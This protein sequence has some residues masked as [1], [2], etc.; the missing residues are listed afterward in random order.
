MRK[1][2]ICLLGILSFVFVQAQSTFKNPII[3][4]MNPDPSICRVGDDFYL[5]TST[6]E[7][8]P[9]LPVYQSK[10]LVHW[11][12]I[13]YALTTPTQ[14]PLMGCTS[15]TGGQYAP[16]IR[17]NNGTFYVICTNYGGQGSQ[18]VFYV[19]ASNPAGPWSNPRW[20]GNWY[21]DPSLMFEN[22]STYFLSPD[23]NGS[24]LL[25]TIN[26]VTGKFIKPL[27]KIA[28]GLGGAA[29]EG[30]HMY[31]INDYYYLM[32]A[33]GGTGY[34]HREVIQRSSSPWGPFVPSPVNPVVSH[35]T[36]PKNPFQAIGHADLVQLP[37]NSWWLVCLGFRPRNGNYHHLGRETFLAPV[38]WSA[39]GWP[40]G[41]TAGIVAE[42]MAVPNLPEY[43]WPEEPVRDDFDSIALRSAWNFI[44]NPHAADWSLSA[45]P[46]FLRLKG[47]KISFREKDS[48]AFIGRRQTA[49]N[50]VASASANFI[51]V[52]GNEEA[53]LVVRG[54]DANHF[55]FVITKLGGKRVLM[56]RK[57]LQDKTTDFKYKE[58]SDSGNVILRISSTDLQYKF[59]VQ[60][61]GKTAE[62]IGTTSTIDLS[63]EKIGG[64]TGT[65]IGMYASGNGFVNVNPADFDWFDFQENPVLP[66]E[67][68][69]GPQELQNNMATPLIDTA[70]STTYDQVK[71]VWNDISNET[72]YVIERM[73][74]NKFDLIGVTTANDTVFTD[75]GLEG[76]TLYIYRILGINDT[77][78]SSPSVS[79]SVFTLPKPGPYTGTPAQIPGKTE[80]ENYDYGIKGVAFFDTDAGNNAGK[81]RTDDV[82]I[83]SCNDT[84]NGFNIGWINS[85]EWVL[86]TVDVNDTI[87]DIELRIASNSGGRIK[88]ELDG[89][90][91]AQTNIA[92]TGGWTTWKTITLNNIKLVSGKNKKLKITFVNGGFNFNWIN[93]VKP[94]LTAI[95]TSPGDVISIYPNPASN[96]LFIKSATFRYSTIEVFNLEGKCLLSASTEYK[97]ENNIQF[98]FPA[99]QY[100]LAL[101]NEQQK[102]ILK[103]SV[104]E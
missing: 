100:V 63:T 76:K 72:G 103:F 6:F 65:Y 18:G 48:P 81:Y 19:T 46:G 74:A 25:G 94:K 85:G 98:S 8:F 45:N 42:E 31:K 26:P 41:G 52:S 73:A 95:E 75:T 36:A 2:L 77:A 67:W 57:Y 24:F 88:L 20:V 43:I 83:E 49:F 53:G 61:N 79:S 14:N 7:Y 44:R 78:Y 96:M 70:Y 28:E 90:L 93:F 99:G 12:R 38:T 3:T 66:F 4:G 16:T 40:K 47:S 23:N 84:G 17:Y 10:D 62:L 22:D 15:G 91:I 33:E 102:R 13:G 30:P 69:G 11:N 71:I 86:Y 39:E 27:V 5:V 50:V 21:V 29:P 87:A 101:N 34:D 80:A 54:D 59:W 92:V 104:V 58:L 64:F 68:Q 51:P 56:L 37:D 1:I 97:P 60:D 55:D 9:G 82:E 32:S 89:A 35:R